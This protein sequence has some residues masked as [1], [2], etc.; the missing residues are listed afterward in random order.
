MARFVAEVPVRWTDQDAYRH[1]NH[2]RAVTLLEEARVGLMFTAAASAGVT[3]F[4]GG[5]LVAGL[6][7]DYHRQIPYRS[8]LRVEMWVDVV[9]AASF[10]I[11]YAMHDGPG[12]A[13]PVAVTAWTRMALFD[14]DA[15][16]PRRLTGTE[17][18]FLEQ[19]DDVGP[20][21]DVRGPAEV[22]R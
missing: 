6:H 13:D 3:G 11:S 8:S 21:A 17:R 10:R 19:W 12:S 1:I 14:L 2:A 5:L 7:V 22:A 4:V 9:R 20:T 16:R 15:G 18:A